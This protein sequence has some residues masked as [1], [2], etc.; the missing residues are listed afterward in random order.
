MQKHTSNLREGNFEDFKAWV[1]EMDQDA[2]RWDQLEADIDSLCVQGE[3]ILKGSKDWN[4]QK[5]P[6]CRVLIQFLF[7]I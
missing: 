5:V 2:S 6:R 1:R 3:E 7:N 4:G